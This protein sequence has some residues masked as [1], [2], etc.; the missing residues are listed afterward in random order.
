MSF[1]EQLTNLRNE[2]GLTR[3]KLAEDLHIPMTTLRNYEQN[4]REPG[5]KFVV[6][7]AQ[8]FGVTTDYILENEKIPTVSED[9]EK[10]AEISVE[11]MRM[12]LSR[13]GLIAEGRDLSEK[14]IVF[15]R[16]VFDLLGVWFGQ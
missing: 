16:G 3:V 10:E 8:Y 1:G 5:H 11:D 4:T 12:L 6:Q 7:V 2:R 15:M 14:D 13:L 9:T